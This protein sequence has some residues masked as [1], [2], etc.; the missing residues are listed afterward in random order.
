[1][2]Q[3]GEINVQGGTVITMFRDYADELKDG[4]VRIATEYAV[5]PNTTVIP[6][7]G[8]EVPSVYDVLPGELHEDYERI[9]PIISGGNVGKNL[10]AGP[11]LP[12]DVVEVLRQAYSDMLSDPAT[13][14]ELASIMAGAA[15]GAE[16][17]YL[18][19]P[20]SGA[21]TQE[22]FQAASESFFANL[23]YYAELQ[24]A[25]YALWE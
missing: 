12:P 8:V 7:E 17:Q 9:L 24:D 2:V 23:D 22:L 4:S 14:E 20:T 18:V 3:R 6:P 13:V 16:Y 10:W 15:E 25:F 21:T 11:D 1:M 19:Q 5:D